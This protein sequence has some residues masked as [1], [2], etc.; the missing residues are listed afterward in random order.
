MEAHCGAARHLPAVAWGA[1]ST[2]GRGEGL[3]QPIETPRYRRQ[4][5]GAVWALPRGRWFELLAAGNGEEALK[6]GADRWRN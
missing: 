3:T 5:N 6:L 4:A 1:P 2:A